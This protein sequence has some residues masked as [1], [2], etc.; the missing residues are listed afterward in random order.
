MIV[1]LLEPDLSRPELVINTVERNRRLLE[2]QTSHLSAWKMR[3]QWKWEK[4]KYFA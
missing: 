4:E 1:A 3:E 2:I